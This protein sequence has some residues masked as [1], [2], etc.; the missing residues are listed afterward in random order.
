[1]LALAILTILVADAHHTTPSPHDTAGRELLEL[2]TNEIRHLMNA[3]ITRPTQSLMHYR[4]W[5][6]WRRA[7]QAL[8]RRLHYRRRSAG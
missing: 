5:S 6:H 8:A 7:H 1:M 4:S 2:T 3:L